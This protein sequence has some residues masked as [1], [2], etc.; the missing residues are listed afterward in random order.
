[1]S[2]KRAES[3]EFVYIT[4]TSDEAISH[5]AH[6]ADGGAY[7]A[8]RPEVVVN[9][10]CI[11]P[12]DRLIAHFHKNVRPFFDQAVVNKLESST[13]SELRN[14]LLPK[15]LSGELS[16]SDAEDHLAEEAEPANV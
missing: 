14:S 1:L 13:L 12:C 10:P 7:P 6:L 2:P 8:V 3:A 11:L 15:L 9:L 16:V 5:L 4:A